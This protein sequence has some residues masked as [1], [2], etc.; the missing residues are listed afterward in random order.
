MCFNEFRGGPGACQNRSCNYA[1]KHDFAS[2]QHYDLALLS[3]LNE[4]FE[5]LHKTPI[6]QKL[7]QPDNARLHE[8]LKRYP[9]LVSAMRNP[10]A[11]T[12]PP[13]QARGP[14]LLT[15]PSVAFAQ[16]QAS[17]PWHKEPALHNVPLDDTEELEKLYIDEAT[18]RVGV[19]PLGTSRSRRRRPKLT[20][21][22]APDGAEGLQTRHTCTHVVR[23]V[24][25]LAQRGC[26]FPSRRLE[27]HGVCH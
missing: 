14:K 25:A 15:R 18:F 4:Q 23:H 12:P 3:T 26:L 27:P 13:V 22:N 5:A 11:P 7:H 16:A 8:E 17:E 9:L 10:N 1:H 20:Q 21:R 19:R 6:A 2:A 24:T